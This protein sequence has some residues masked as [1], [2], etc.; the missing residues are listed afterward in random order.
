MNFRDIVIITKVLQGAFFVFFK[1]KSH[2][3]AGFGG[4]ILKTKNNLIHYIVLLG[5]FALILL[6]VPMR[7]RAAD[8]SC[9]AGC[10]WD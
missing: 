8:G 4:M 6:A 7:G 1:S 2:R 9:G 10:P 3:I 5:I